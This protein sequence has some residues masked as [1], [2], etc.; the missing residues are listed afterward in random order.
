MLVL[1]TNQNHRKFLDIPKVPKDIWTSQQI[2]KNL[3]DS[4]KSLLK[5]QTYLTKN[6]IPFGTIMESTYNGG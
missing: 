2:A 5:T 3:K 1:T 6:L 4:D